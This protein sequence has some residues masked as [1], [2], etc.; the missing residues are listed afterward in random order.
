MSPD[1]SNMLKLGAMLLA[2]TLVFSFKSAYGDPSLHSK[3][4]KSKALKSK[5]LAVVN[6]REITDAMLKRYQK[7]RGIPKGTDAKIQ[8]KRMLEELIN[9]EL[10]YQD[11]Q[12]KKIDQSTSVKATIENARMDIVVGAMLKQISDTSPT[13]DAD[14]KKEYDNNLQRMEVTEFRARHILLKTE[15]DAKSVIQQLDKGVEF[16]SLAIKKSTGPSGPGGGELGWF[17][18]NQMLPPFSNAVAKL[19]K[20][21]Y[22]KTP[23]NTKFG[24]HVILREDSRKLPTPSFEAMKEQVRMRLQNKQVENYIGSLRN[25]AAIERHF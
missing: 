25:G 19:K 11:A 24:W 20:G 14:I 8:R 13:T 15:S 7:L 21:Q 18:P 4:I 5:V 6:N 16:A 1:E 22:T 23:V 9:R 17:K 12:K 3:G 2:L 10:I